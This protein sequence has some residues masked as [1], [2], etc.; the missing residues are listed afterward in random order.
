MLSDKIFP[1]LLESFK[2]YYNVSTEN[3]EPP[4]EAEAVFASHNEQYFLVKAAK[5]ADIDTYEYVYFVHK[6]NI[7]YDE[8]VSL[9]DTAWSRGSAKVNPCEGHRYTDVTLFIVADT[10]E[11]EA[12]KKA[13]MISH[14][15]SYK[16]GF[17][18]Y[19]HF[20]LVTMESSSK[21][22]VTN[23]QG[24]IYKKLSCNIF[25]QTTI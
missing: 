25:N 1:I 19:S 9:A 23:R 17:Y 11:K 2:R 7:G 16:M 6:E 21:K 12:V 4:F 14:N 22:V 15:V 10:I 8:L 24:D 5:V 13:K 3:I 20:K 18:G